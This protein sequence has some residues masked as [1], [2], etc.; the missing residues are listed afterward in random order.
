MG[1]QGERCP[2]FPKHK[3]EVQLIL[4]L[5]EMSVMDKGTRARIK[6]GQVMAACIIFLPTE[7]TVNVPGG[8]F[9]Q[10]ALSPPRED[11]GL[12]L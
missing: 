3:D 10:A 6:T 1:G 5:R 12:I 9:S 4:G 11:T 2:L 8:S 7:S